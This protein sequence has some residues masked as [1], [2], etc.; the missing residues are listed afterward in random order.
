MYLYRMK[1]YR[2]SIENAFLS[3]VLEEMVY[4]KNAN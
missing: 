3:Y 2:E 1:V 4:D